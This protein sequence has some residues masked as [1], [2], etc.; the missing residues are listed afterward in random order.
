M[1]Q[2]TILV[3]QE[4]VYYILSGTPRS[5]QKCF[6]SDLRVE[7]L[8]ENHLLLICGKMP[9]LRCVF[10]RAS[11]VIGHPSHAVPVSSQNGDRMA[12]FE[13]I[14][15]SKFPILYTYTP[16]LFAISKKGNDD[17]GEASE[18]GSEV[19]C[20][21]RHSR[22][23]SPSPLTPLQRPFHTGRS[24]GKFYPLPCISYDK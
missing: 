23:P 13:F 14:Q 21:I 12:F 9:G 20:Q 19:G 8:G 6:W 2:S 15:S 7:F 11:G 22:S 10:D 18:G 17:V 24:G 5:P 4:V 3:N 16:L 1:G